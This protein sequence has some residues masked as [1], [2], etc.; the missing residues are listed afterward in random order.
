MSGCNFYISMEIE[1][2]PFIFVIII[3]KEL[4]GDSGRR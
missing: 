4:P 3:A 2:S 1:I